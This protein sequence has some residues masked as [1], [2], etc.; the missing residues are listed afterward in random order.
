MH[1]MKT[2]PHL[3]MVNKRSICIYMVY[4]LQAM[5]KLNLKHEPALAVLQLGGR[6]AAVQNA[7]NNAVA[8]INQIAVLRAHHV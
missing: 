7:E 6:A 4:Q 1:G 8:V 5:T 2:C 3:K